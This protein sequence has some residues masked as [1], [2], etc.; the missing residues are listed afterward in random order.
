VST[1]Q[2]KKGVASM[3]SAATHKTDVIGKNI[4]VDKKGIK[5]TNIYLEITNICNLNCSF[6][7]GNKRKKEYLSIDNLKAIL[8]KLKGY[9]DTLYLH[10]MGEPLVHPN[11]NEI[12]N[13][14]SRY[15]KV[16]ITT[17]GY[18]INKIKDNHN[19][20]KINISLQ[21][22]KSVSDI[23]S[24]LNNIYS[25]LEEIKK[26]TIINYR[27][28]NKQVNM[29]KVLSNLE[30]HYKKKIK[31]NTKLES[32]VYIDFQEPFIWP[33][34]NNDYYNEV[35]SCMGLRK[36]IGIL[37]NGDVIPCC[38]DYNDNMK[39]GNI[40]E[41]D[42]DTILNSKKALDMKKGF[43]ENKKIEKMC[44]HCNFYSR[45]KDGVGYGK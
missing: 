37:V 30:K 5:F 9:T 35:G 17:N 44:C 27:I 23:D 34:I 36:H 3:Y 20:N 40:Y 38:L 11:I 26:H 16:N 41:E 14:I 19:I 15:F 10:I 25:C 39:L 22:I 1:N 43:L 33:D 8:P 18:L 2:N 6:C 24:Y 28:W 42:L 12:I 13:E 21:S 29:D 45:I 7:I 32:N 31:G 4:V